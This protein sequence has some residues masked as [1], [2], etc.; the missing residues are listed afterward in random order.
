MT[1]ASDISGRTSCLQR[2]LYGSRSIG[3][4]GRTVVTSADQVPT[5]RPAAEH[6]VAL[7]PR[8][9]EL[10]RHLAAGRSTAQTAAAMSL[11]ANTVRTRIRRVQDKLAATDRRDAVRAAREYGIV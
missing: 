7:N 10:L 6:A 4:A 2:P 1:S 5:P 3:H 8:D 11:T 9:L